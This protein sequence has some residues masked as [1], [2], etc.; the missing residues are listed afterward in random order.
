LLAIN[1]SGQPIFTDASMTCPVLEVRVDAGAV[2]SA[3]VMQ[4][5][6]AYRR[7]VASGYAATRA[8]LRSTL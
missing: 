6:D 3:E 7:V 8:A 4:L 1:A 5:G 2:S